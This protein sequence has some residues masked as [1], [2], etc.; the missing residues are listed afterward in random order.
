MERNSIFAD[1]HTHTV[2][3]H[4]AGSVDQN[5]ERAIELGLTEIAISDHGPGH[6]KYNIRDMQAYVADISRAKE[7]YG[8]KIKVIS[9][10]ECNLCGLDGSVDMPE[11]P[12]DMHIMGF[13]KLARMS[14]LGGYWHFYVTRLFKNIGIKKTTRAYLSALD[15]YDIDIISHPGYA[16]NCD[17]IALGRACR[18]KGVLFE[19]NQKHKEQSPDMLRRVAQTGC[20][21]VIS[22]DAHKSEDVGGVEIALEKAAAAGL[23][24]REV[25]NLR[26]A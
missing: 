18:D 25:V 19:I 17:L 8:N 1:Y 16:I 3:S 9:S 21:F 12:L 7:K 4:G 24:C 14:S 6:F 20:K 2:H 13:H 23:T 5:I 26:E 10:V 15:K 11:Q 22:S